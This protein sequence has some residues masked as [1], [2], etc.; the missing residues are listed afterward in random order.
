ML[1]NW[2]LFSFVDILLGV[3][4]LDSFLDEDDD[5]NR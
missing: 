1:S 3:V 5:V 2:F 4:L